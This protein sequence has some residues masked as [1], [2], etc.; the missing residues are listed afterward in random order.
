MSGCVNEN[1]D[2]DPDASINCVVVTID[3]DLACDEECK[4]E[5]EKQR[6]HFFNHTIH[7]DAAMTDWWKGKE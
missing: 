1:C 4:R 3:G 6:D 5:Y 2:K 7:S